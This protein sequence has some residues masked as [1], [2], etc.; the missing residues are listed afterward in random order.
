MIDAV[1]ELAREGVLGD[2]LYAN[3]LVMMSEL[4]EVLLNFFESK[5]LR[6]SLV[7]TTVMALQR[8]ACLELKLTNMWPAA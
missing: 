3:Y 2:L 1:A 6:V 5:S 8:M 4:I 7:K